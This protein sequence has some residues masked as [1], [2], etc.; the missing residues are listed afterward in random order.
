M[1]RP[2]RVAP[3]GPPKG[4]DICAEFRR[5]GLQN[6]SS[7]VPASFLT[8]QRVP[9]CFEALRS[10]RLPENFEPPTDSP[11]RLNL[12]S[13]EIDNINA[14]FD[15]LALF[16]PLTDKVE[17]S[18]KTLHSLMLDTWKNGA[19]KWLLFFYNAG[20]DLNDTI[21]NSDR[22]KFT[23]FSKSTCFLTLTLV[24]KGVTVSTPLCKELLKC[25]EMLEVMGCLWVDN[26][27]LEPLPL[28]HHFVHEE[29]TVAI[30][31][32]ELDDSTPREDKSSGQSIVFAAAIGH[33]GAKAVMKAAT[34]N[35]ERLIDPSVRRLN[36]EEL[37][38]EA[39]LL[40]SLG[41]TPSL[42]EAMHEVG[43]LTVVGQAIGA[44]AEAKHTRSRIVDERDGVLAHKAVEMLTGLILIEY[45]YKGDDMSALAEAAKAGL[46][47][48]LWMARVEFGKFTGCKTA[49]NH[50][51]RE[52]IG[53]FSG[54]V[55]LDTAND[56]HRSQLDL[57]FSLACR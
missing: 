27:S 21:A 55:H 40:A 2:R 20:S 36:A 44:L 16:Q 6:P 24:L 50:V 8:D 47:K 42:C 43:T 1:S 41:K 31:N 11:C 3:T 45:L 56:V 19:W 33:K 49:V 54:S 5:L 4:L 9:E 53:D 10:D 37:H 13:V 57:P 38:K 28:P 51:I 34:K 48:H 30:Q 35:L 14:A 25:H 7:K 29:L 26:P 18:N 15:A 22:P 17:R 23:L 52:I 12:S 46:V 39:F 32:I